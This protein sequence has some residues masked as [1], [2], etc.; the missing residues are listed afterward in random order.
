[1]ERPRDKAG[2]FKVLIVEDSALFRKLLKDTL[3]DRFPTIGIYE[4]KDGKEALHEVEAIHPDVIFMDIRLPEGNG[5][6][7]TKKIKGRHPNVIVIILTAYDLPEYREVSLEYADYFFSKGGS[8]TEN[9]LRLLKTI[10]ST[11]G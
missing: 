9:I 6:D 1:M 2:G 3:H 4:A 8:K 7:L 10:L 5:L 11:T